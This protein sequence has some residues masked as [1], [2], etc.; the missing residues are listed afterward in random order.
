MNRFSKTKKDY[1]IVKDIALP[2]IIFVLVLCLFFFG[3]NSI[4]STT[5][6]EQ[7]KATENAVMR[8]VV[9][10]YALEGMYP[11]NIEYLEEKYGLTIDH[12][13]YIVDYISFASNLMPDVTVLNVPNQ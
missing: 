2:A 8:A 3:L 10:C 13:R 9:H 5:K 1:S 11:P 6:D 12:T 7:F 4:T